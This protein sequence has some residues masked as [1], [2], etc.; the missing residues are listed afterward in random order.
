[1]PQLRRCHEAQQFAFDFGEPS[2]YATA[3][4]DED[5]LVMRYGLDDGEINERLGVLLPGELADLLDIAVAVYMSDRLAVRGGPSQPDWRR[6]LAIQIPVRHI[7]LWRG[8]DV[9]D[10]LHNVLSFLTQDDWQISLCQRPTRIRRLAQSQQHLLSNHVSG[11]PVHVGLLSGGLDSFVGTAAAIGREPAREYVCVSG[12]ANYRQG[13]RQ[14]EQVKCLRSLSPRSLTHVRIACWLQDAGEVR[15]EP[16]RRT[17]GF[18]FLALGA[19]AALTA[20]TDT[21]W[22][23]ENGVGALNLPFADGELGVSTSRS[24]HPKTL[25][26][27][28]ALVSLIA[29]S[30]FTIRNG[31]VL[32]TKAQMCSDPRL[33]P[34]RTGIPRTFS[35][36]AF[37]LRQR[38]ASQ[39]GVCTS[40]LLRRMALWNA[41][42][43]EYDAVGYRYDV[44]SPTLALG[45]RQA[46][47]ISEMDWQVA[48]LASAISQP[49][50]WRGLVN[51]F[52]SLVEAQQSLAGHLDLSDAAVA[53]QLVELYRWHCEEWRRFPG[54]PL[55]MVRREAA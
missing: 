34:V 53:V 44:C 33:A 19:A 6:A 1:M 14:K 48:R 52:P 31:A 23:Y 51:E 47:G 7:E 32:R 39:C 21:L 25:K 10:A 50:P 12:V 3:F 40:C 35:C 9:Q 28:G 13:D 36:D 41:G 43:S 49:D 38:G 42:L 8:H 2:R 29:G 26:R 15:Q 4:E 17:R 55:A 54:A 37:P 20:G 24:V 27:M 45:V 11:G 22:L 30:A 5:G 18:L 16:T 46:R